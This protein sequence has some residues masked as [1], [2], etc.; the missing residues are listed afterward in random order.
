MAGLERMTLSRHTCNVNYIELFFFTLFVMIIV[1]NLR[2]TTPDSVM[3][4]EIAVT[5]VQCLCAATIRGNYAQ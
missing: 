5:A 3:A 2:R 4:I 1:C